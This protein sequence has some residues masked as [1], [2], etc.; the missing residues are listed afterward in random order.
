MTPERRKL[1]QCILAYTSLAILFTSSATALSAYFTL[2]VPKDPVWVVIGALG[3]IAYVVGALV[4]G[5]MSR[6]TKRWLTA[7]LV[8]G[9]NMLMMTTGAATD[10]TVVAYAIGIVF[11]IL[12]CMLAFS[13]AAPAWFLRGLSTVLSV[14]LVAC[15]IASLVAYVVFSFIT[16]DQAQNYL[17]YALAYAVAAIFSLFIAVDVHHYVN[18]CDGDYCCEDGSIEIWL[19]FVNVLERVIYLMQ[20]E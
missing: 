8:I 2:E 16:D 14:A 18:D 3:V 12:V 20:D 19:D 13:F 10:A 5:D 11:C 15:L 4:A 17:K 7:M 1:F 9:V 6:S